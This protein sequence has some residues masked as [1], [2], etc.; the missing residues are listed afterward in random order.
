LLAIHKTRLHLIILI[1]TILSNTKK[2]L[3]LAI[4]I[5]GA[6]SFF[7]S[8]ILLKEVLNEEAYGQYS[9]TITYF[10]VIFIFGLLGLEQIFLRYSNFIAVNTIETQKFQVSLIIKTILLTSTIGTLFFSFY[11]K[12]EFKIN[13]ILLYLSSISIVALLYLFNI[14]RLN[15]DFVF[16]QVVA[17]FWRIILLVL[18]E[19]LFFL[20]ISD[21]NVLL[22]FIMLGI[23]FSF[24][25]AFFVFFK[26]IQ[27]VY[28]ENHTPKDIIK[29][30]FQ[31][32]ISIATFSLLTFGDRF[33]IQNKFGFEEF[34]NYFYLTNFFLAPF[35][36]LQNYIGF[37]QLIFFKNNFTIK[38]FDAFNK[39]VIFFGVLLA[40]FLFITPN[41]LMYLKI[42]TF[43]FDKYTSI[44]ILLL[45]LGIIRLYSSS[46]SSAFEAKTN[47]DSL[48]KANLIFILLA[49]VIVVFAVLVFNS[50][51]LIIATVSL[52]W[53]LRTL[54]YKSVLLKQI[55][56]EL[57]N[58]T[59]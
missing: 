57:K 59:E 4:I 27:F 46:I 28:N 51:E 35:S 13:F 42:I 32:F 5:F 23:L 3:S 55:Q 20:K 19:V 7:L 53:L 26:R 31:F 21:L 54:I 6:G 30:S 49:L 12:E 10:S 9:I 29:T 41:L 15:T 40:V 52:I 2:H 47:I 50:L 18:A 33:V 16:A 17:N 58:K 56:K 48:K 11:F 38:A 36:I 24:L 39:K 34:G 37:K 43:E 45:I 8:N 14:F 22:N 1:K 44:T 25:L